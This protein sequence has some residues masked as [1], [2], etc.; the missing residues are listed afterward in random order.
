MYKRFSFWFLIL[1]VVVAAFFIY[2]KST[3]A[4]TVKVAPVKRQS[5]EITVT[6]T[7][8]GIVKAEKEIKITAQRTGR[9]NKLYVEEGQEVKQGQLLCEIDPAEAMINLQKAE[10]SLMAAKARLAEAKANLEDVERNLKRAEHLY[11]KG[12][13]SK[14]DIDTARNDYD[15][16]QE[17]IRFFDAQY[18]EAKASGGLASLQYRYSFLRAPVSGVIS[19]RPVEVGDMAMPGTLIAGLV[20]P[21]NLYI[22]ASIDEVDVGRVSI[23]QPV[24]VTMDAYPQRLF[25]G[26]VFMISPIVIGIKQQTRTFEVRVSLDKT[27]AVIKPGMSADIEIITSSVPNTL[28]L[29][30]QAVIEKD[31]GRYVFIKDGDRAVLR[32]VETGLYNWTFTEIKSGLKEGDLVITTPDKAGLRDGSRVKT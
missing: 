23:G 14:R 12:L 3:N 26:R 1:A 30:T 9:I 13:I 5:L 16:S 2:R 7:S 17:D 22:Q 21:E 31:S 11:N 18:K 19:Q 10:A 29:P 32:K 20:S 4:I 24:K 6:S 15:V 28:L 8:T 27:D 25:N